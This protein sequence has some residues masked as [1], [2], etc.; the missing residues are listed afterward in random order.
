M[1]PQEGTYYMVTYLPSGDE[2]KFWV[3]LGKAEVFGL[4]DLIRM[5][6]IIIEARNFHE[7][8]FWGGIL[9]WA[10]LGI[11]ALLLGGWALL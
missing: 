1:L 8:F 10:Y 11:V 6:V 3:A 2:G 7:V 5:P 4:W 9:G